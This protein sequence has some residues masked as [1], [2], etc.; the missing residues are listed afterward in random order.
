MGK[1]YRILI[2]L[3][4]IIASL[5]CYQYGGQTGIF[6]FIIL[7]FLF[8]AAFWLKLFPIKKKRD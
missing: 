6:V 5:I 4:L 3:A 8:E 1:M 2:L 7:G